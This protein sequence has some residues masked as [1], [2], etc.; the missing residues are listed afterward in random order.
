MKSY[1]RS[2]ADSVRKNISV[3]VDQCDGR[4]GCNYPRITVIKLIRLFVYL[5]PFFNFCFYFFRGFAAPAFSFGSRSTGS[6]F[7]AFPNCWPVLYSALCATLLR[8]S[9]SAKRWRELSILLFPLASFTM[10][11]QTLL[12][13]ILCRAVFS[14]NIEPVLLC[15]SDGVGVVPFPYPAL[16]E[17]IHLVPLGVLTTVLFV[18]WYTNE[19][20]EEIVSV[21]CQCVLKPLCYI[22]SFLLSSQMYVFCSPMLAKSF[23]CCLERRLAFGYFYFKFAIGLP[24]CGQLKCISNFSS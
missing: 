6:Q 7:G 16:L 14:V 17:P 15:V 20:K 12:Y 9:S 5:F 18:S 10:H 2:P 1:E 4:T 21:M 22:A 11:F 8:F 13:S 19:G 3:L 23:S 24:S